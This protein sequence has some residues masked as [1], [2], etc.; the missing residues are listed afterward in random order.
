MSG[1]L[2]E[3]LGMEAKPIG[4]VQRAYNDHKRYLSGKAL[5]T[6]L[7][8]IV[9]LLDDNFPYWIK[10]ENPDPS[11]PGE[12]IGAKSNLVIPILERGDFNDAGYTFDETRVKSLLN[13]PALLRNPNCIHQNL[14][15]AERGHGGIKGLHVYV[16]Y[17]RHNVRRVAFTAP[18]PRSGRTILVSSFFTTGAWIKDCAANP[19]TYVKAA[20]RCTCCI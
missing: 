13:I 1:D 12:T 14:R 8:E 7:P 10:L 17:V 9:H 20:A 19:A 18:C 6:P 11:R 2:R 15:H 4:R 5:T 3:T 16:E